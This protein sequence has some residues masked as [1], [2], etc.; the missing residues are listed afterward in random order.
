RI[1]GARAC[2]QPP[3]GHG[4]RCP[5]AR[6]APRRRGLRP[7]CTGRRLPGRAAPG[8][9]RMGRRARRG[10]RVR[11]AGVGARLAGRAAARPVRAAGRLETPVAPRTALDRAEAARVPAVNAAIRLLNR[12]LNPML[13][14]LQP[15]ADLR[16]VVLAIDAAGPGAAD[17]G[18]ATGVRVTAQAASA[19][20]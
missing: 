12:P 19:E 17:R 5:G 20:E 14:A 4:I 7:A 13:R 1:V 11:A 6:S 16:V 3:G 9:A 10:A 8:A 15:P 18:G 2:A